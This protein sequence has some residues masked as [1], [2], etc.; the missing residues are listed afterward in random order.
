MDGG[1]PPP[2]P[3]NIVA[4]FMKT[5][6]ISGSLW[7]LTM[8]LGLE[9]QSI[10]ACWILGF[11]NAIASSGS[12]MSFWMASC[13]VMPMAANCSCTSGEFMSGMPSPGEKPP[14]P[15]FICFMIPLSWSLYMGLLRSISKVSGLRIIS[16]RYGYIISCIWGLRSMFCM[17]SRSSSESSP[18]PTGSPVTVS[19]SVSAAA[20]G[21]ALVEGPASSVASAKKLPEPTLPDSFF[22]SSFFSSFFASVA[23]AVAV[24]A[25]GAAGLGASFFSVGFT[26]TTPGLAAA[27][28]LGGVKLGGGKGGK[29]PAPAAPPGAPPIPGMPPIPGAPPA[30]LP[31]CFIICWSIMDCMSPFLPPTN[32]ITLP[33][34]TASAT[35][36][37]TSIH[38]GVSPPF[39]WGGG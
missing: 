34:P 37:P 10:T 23:V 18:S 25:A 9:E 26:S 2:A 38:P 3:G 30:W 1:I 14:P 4:S 35:P 39:F 24:A 7:Y 36:R 13:G 11:W 8:L 12:P 20:K 29:P 21:L 22:S 16:G 28:G 5:F 31:I 15:S 19:V 6:M 27:A 17:Y 32:S 33:K